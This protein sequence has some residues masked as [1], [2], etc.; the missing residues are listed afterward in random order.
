MNPA[1]RP[2]GRR[3]ARICFVAPNAY[4]V[5]KQDT[6]HGFMGGAELQQALIGEELAKRGY[7]VSFITMRHG[8]EETERL[9]PFEVF[10]TYGPD[11]GIPVLRFVHPRL[12]RLWRALV[13]SDADLYFVR[14]ATFR[15]APVVYFARRAG[16]KV[17]FSGADDPD[18]DPKSVKIQYLRDRLLYFWGLRRCDAITVQNRWQQRSLRENFGRDAPIIHNGFRRVEAPSSSPGHDV[19]WV[20]KIL[21]RKRPQWLLEL[22]KGI[23]D[24]SFVMI[25]G[26]SRASATES[27]FYREVEARA[28]PIPNLRFKGFL[29]FGEVEKEFDN[30]RI[31]V[32]TSE[33]EGFPNTFLQAWSR[34]V[35]VI[36]FV[37]PD[38]LLER[39]QLGLVVKSLDE[40]I[41]KVRD[42]LEGRIVFDRARIKAF[43]E[44]NFLLENVVDRYERVFRSVLT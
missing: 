4:S 16:R 3:G 9:G 6:D 40:L 10:T 13:Q 21:R 35:P 20:A 19:L 32:N 11:E 43:Y 41:R 38:E 17:V 15:L 31:F 14:G 8:R 39:H 25:G 12:T 5:L 30:A 29:A 26:Q 7:S 1:D 36:S 37:N 2:Q 27:A 22:A 28:R 33:H 34:G 18:F 23:P 44:E 42:V 24:A